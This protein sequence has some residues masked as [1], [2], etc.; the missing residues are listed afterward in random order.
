M[1]PP[2]P[3][4]PRQKHRSCIARNP[5]NNSGLKISVADMDI[6][7][8]IRK[9]VRRGEK[10]IGH[11]VRPK[12]FIVC[13]TRLYFMCLW[14][15]LPFCQNCKKSKKSKVHNIHHVQIQFTTNCNQCHRMTDPSPK[16]PDILSDASLAN[17]L[18]L[19]IYSTFMLIHILLWS[20]ASTVS[21]KLYNAILQ[22]AKS[23]C[24]VGR[25]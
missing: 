14:S 5:G 6:V 21:S 11:Y 3:E 8:P 25:L 9:I 2:F 7:R 1:N 17:I 23:A 19:V 4:N 18:R 15:L 16:T 10:G 22:I 13:S 12:E 20:T 24:K